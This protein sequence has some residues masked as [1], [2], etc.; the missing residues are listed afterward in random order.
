MSAGD[1]ITV[2][3]PHDFPVQ[4]QRLIRASH[5]ALRQCD[6]SQISGLTI[7]ISTAADLRDLNRRHRRIDAATDVLTYPAPRLPAAINLA[8]QHLGDI[9]VAYDYVSTASQLRATC[10][11]ETLCL[12]VIHGT[13]HLMGYEHGSADGRAAMW[14][15]QEAALEKMGIDPSI[16]RQYGASLMASQERRQVKR[17]LD[18]DPSAYAMMTSA[19]RFR[20]FSYA[21]SG[22]AYMLRYQK[23]TRI[24]LAAT[25]LV[26]IFGLWLELGLRDWPL[27]L[28]AMA[29]VWVAEFINA[30]I[31]A[32]VDISSPQYHALAKVAKDVAAGAVLLASIFALIIGLLLLGPPLLDKLASG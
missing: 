9:L 25:V 8:A 10:L 14:A 23:N 7:V 3:N 22:C 32:A 24:M 1:C 12:L 11:H 5:A 16:V 13:L 19:N 2:Q 20:S 17:A 28:L 27:L 15:A 30:A 26:V 21:V 18:T 6:A 29:Q 4:Q 31:E